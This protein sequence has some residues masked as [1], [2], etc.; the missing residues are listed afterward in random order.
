MS[1]VLTPML[2]SLSKLRACVGSK[3]VG[4]ANEITAKSSAEMININALITQNGR[5][6]QAQSCLQELIDGAPLRADLGFAYA[7]LLELIAQESGRYLSNE[8]WAGIAFGLIEQVDQWLCGNGVS[9]GPLDMMMRGAPIALP[10]IEDFPQIGYIPNESAATAL[11]SFPTTLIA[12]TALSLRPAA[13]EYRQW[14]EAAVQ[15]Q[16]DLIAFYY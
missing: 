1:Y 7:Y 13:A 9:A 12:N 10:V 5:T 11:L 4:L 2:V 8:H 16:S 14:L 6:G 3:Q 15:T